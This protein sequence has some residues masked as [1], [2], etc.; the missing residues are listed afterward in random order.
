MQN[1]SRRTLFKRLSALLAGGALSPS[2]V[3]KAQRSAP[4]QSSPARAEDC[5]CTLAADGTP[6]DVG[7]S[8]IRPLIERYSI[9]LRDRERIY[10]LPGSD[11]RQSAMEKFYTEEL[12]LLDEIRFD[13]MSQAGKVDYLLLRDRLLREQQQVVQDGRAD[14]E[15]AALIPFQQTIIGFEEARRRMETIDGQKSALALEKLV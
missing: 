6:L 2:G 4:K 11:A 5:N 3:L 14:A 9:E 8:E 15:I 13:E 1:S 7:T 12:H 10:P